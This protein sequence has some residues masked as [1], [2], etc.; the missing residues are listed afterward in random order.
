[1]IHAKCK[2][3]GHVYQIDPKQK[4]STYILK[5]PPPQE[6][7]DTADS[8]AKGIE[9]GGTPPGE[10]V[11]SA[12]DEIA[13][14]NGNNQHSGGSVDE[15]DDDDWAPEPEGETEKLSGEVCLQFIQI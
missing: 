2:A 10:E 7:G 4:L 1:M 5:N 11:A 12:V 8:T 3:C 13:T 9:N 15:A 6:N 14:D